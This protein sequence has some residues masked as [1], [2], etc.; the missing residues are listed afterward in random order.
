[1]V[2]LFEMNPLK[3]EFFDCESYIT[4]IDDLVV[5]LIEGLNY[6]RMQDSSVDG[7]GANGNENK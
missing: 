7:G 4:T 1:M 3:V 5:S 6:D 2:M